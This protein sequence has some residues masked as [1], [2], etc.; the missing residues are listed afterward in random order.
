MAQSVADIFNAFLKAGFS[1]A[2]A[3][4]LTATSYFE[5]SYGT[6]AG[7]GGGLL[8]FTPGTWQSTGVTCSISDTN[9]QAQAAKALV[10]Q[11]GGDNFFPTVWFTNWFLPEQAQG[12]VTAG[13]YA[14]AIASVE[15]AVGVQTSA[16][17]DVQSWV[18]QGSPSGP[19][20]Q[21]AGAAVLSPITSVAGNVLGSVG[22]GIL[23]AGQ[24]LGKAILPWIL[25]VGLLFFF[26]IMFGREVGH[27][28]APSA[29]EQS[30]GGRTA[31]AGVAE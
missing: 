30:S 11:H 7:N 1:Q 10:N 5:S 17:S 2:E 22:Q 18:S 6:Q 27:S 31:A 28:S 20:Y 25:L 23:G 15:Q 16:A 21:Q 8:Q 3:S 19:T 14:A 26:I 9:C 13:G 12:H 4:I 29:A 24:S